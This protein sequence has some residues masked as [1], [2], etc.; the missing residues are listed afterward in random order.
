[1]TRFK[2]R[3]VALRGQCKSLE[4]MLGVSKQLLEDERRSHK[5]VT[6]Q[7]A[8]KHASE[9]DALRGQL[10]EEQRQR[11]CLET[12]LAQTVSDGQMLEQKLQ[13]VV[14]RGSELE[15]ELGCLRKS[16]ELEVAKASDDRSEATKLE[17]ELRERTTALVSENKR[18]HSALQATNMVSGTR[19]DRI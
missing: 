6:E 17:A 4:E 18:V 3:A 12:Q 16:H 13:G 14:Q 19:R 8:L 15:N 7:A 5:Q 1:V 10:G 11:A 2:E 9:T